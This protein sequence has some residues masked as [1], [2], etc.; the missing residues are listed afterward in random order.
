[1]DEHFRTAPIEQ[2]LPIT[3]AVLGVWY[4]KPSHYSHSTNS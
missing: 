2:N 1:M 4:V 3:L